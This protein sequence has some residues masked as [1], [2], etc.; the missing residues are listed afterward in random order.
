[1]LLLGSIL[2]LLVILW[3]IV[4]EDVGGDGS[5]LDENVGTFVP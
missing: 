4:D 5:L 2:G 1:M 3:H